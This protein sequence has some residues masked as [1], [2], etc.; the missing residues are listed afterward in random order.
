MEKK[1]KSFRHSFEHQILR[2]YYLKKPMRF[3]ETM[4]P[5]GAL[6]RIFDSLCRDRGEENLYSPEQFS[7]EMMPA[8]DGTQALRL[9]MPIPEEP[10]ECYRIYAFCDES[11]IN[12]GYFTIEKSLGDAGQDYCIC[13]WM[14]LEGKPMMHLIL[15][16][17]GEKAE[18]EHCAEFY[19]MYT[20]AELYERLEEAKAKAR[21]MT[22]EEA[23]SFREELRKAV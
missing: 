22:E 13:R 8:A 15:D 3:V 4:R 16:D 12:P 2:D 10:L 18:F 6:Y 23:R 1:Q 5:D 21:P 19:R 11:G 14:Q 17:A 9:T 20:A 7:A